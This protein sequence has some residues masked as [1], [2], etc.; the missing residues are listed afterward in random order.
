MPALVDVGKA[1]EAVHDA[2]E[3][4]ALPEVAPAAELEMAA[5]DDVTV[6]MEADEVVVGM[7]EVVPFSVTVRYEV[8][9][10]KLVEK[11][12]APASA[13]LPLAADELAVGAAPSVDDKSDIIED[14][15]VASLELSDI[16]EDEAVASSGSGFMDDEAMAELELDGM[17]S[18]WTGSCFFS[19][20]VRSLCEQGVV[21]KGVGAM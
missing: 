6:W 9:S 5:E 4:V 20:S 18:P 3:E 1:D 11:E 8:M 19:S 10:M 12:V 15:A 16:M 14:E 21:G 2:T 7:T 13:L 17:P